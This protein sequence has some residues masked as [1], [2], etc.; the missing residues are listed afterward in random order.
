MIVTT[1]PTGPPDVA[2]EDRS[3]EPTVE[4][5]QLQLERANQRLTDALQESRLL[6]AELKDLRYHV[7]RAM[8]HLGQARSG[9]PLGFTSILLAELRS[10][11][12]QALGLDAN[13][14]MR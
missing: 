9:D 8:F 10:D 6:K 13:G 14:R 1:D 5:L 11:L 2:P 4:Q 12:H 3:Y 7:N